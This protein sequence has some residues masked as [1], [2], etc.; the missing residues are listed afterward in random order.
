MPD[1]DPI[2][3]ADDLDDMVVVLDRDGW[4]QGIYHDV[5]FD[6]DGRP[7]R[8]AHCI[9]GA[10]QT[11]DIYR[12]DE[13]DLMDHLTGVLIAR[14]QLPW[15]DLSEGYPVNVMDWNDEDD[16]EYPEVREFL[17]SVSK[18]LRNQ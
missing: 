13:D 15:Q 17:V 14:G 11:L 5:T 9:V 4:T 7:V 6:D 12:V 16:R 18:E 10:H 2:D 1:V 3:L 8:N